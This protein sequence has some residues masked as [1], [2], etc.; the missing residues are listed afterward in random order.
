MSTG[1]GVSEEWILVRRGEGGLGGG[2]DKDCWV[3]ERTEKDKS[4]KR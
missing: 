4:R 2:E 3:E 1:P